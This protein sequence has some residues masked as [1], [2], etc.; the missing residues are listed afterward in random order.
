M[1]IRSKFIL[2]IVI[3]VIIS[4]AVISIAVSVKLGGT[5]TE[6][7]EMSSQEE[8]VLVD[9]TVNQI[10]KSPAEV[11]K[12][13][14]SLPSLVNGLGN[15]TKYFELPPG[16]HPIERD[17]MSPAERS[18]FKTFERL[19]QSHPE[20][21]YVYA[22]LEDGGYTQSPDEAMGAGYDPRKRPWYTQGM[23]SSED[24]TLLSAYITTEGVPNIGMVSKVRDA[25]GKV[26]GISAADISL[27]KLTEIASSIH[28]G[29]TGYIM[30]VQGDGTIL[31]DPRHK[32]Y[33][34]K[35]MTELS[36]AFT[37]LSDTAK[38][39]VEDLS[40]DDKDMFGCVHVSPET[41]WKYIALI[42]RSEI[43]A[44]SNTAIIQ[45]VGI[46]LV[47]ALIF[48][49]LG[50][51]VANSLTKP[52]LMSGDFTK[53]IA[54]G[55]L[56]ASINISGKDEIATLAKDLGNMGSKLRQIVG[57]VRITVDGVATGS[58]ELSATAETLAQGATEQASN[59]EEVASSMEQMVANISQNAENAKETEQIASRSAA[60]AEK[61]GAAVAQTV[62]AMREI[63]DKISV[64][65]EI[66]RQTN[67][68]A[69]N[70]AIEAARA[71]EHGKGFA[72]VAA[73]VRKLAERSGSAAG[74]ISELSASSVQVA[75]EAGEMLAKMVPDI[76]H[77]A[78]L[79]QE[80]TAASNEQ[81]TGSEGV[82]SAIHQ[83]DQ[84]IQQIAA[85]S[86]EMSGTSA[87]LSSQATHLKDTVAF[88]NI[89]NLGG[90]SVT[91]TAHSRK[92]ALEVGTQPQVQPEGSGVALE[93]D[94]SDEFERF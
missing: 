8:L 44:S 21:A 41:G 17:T 65:E 86:E 4:V 58:Q 80:I 18:A 38:G 28:I 57:E 54:S 87:E 37:T 27:Q 22:G 88:F 71:G 62:S 84:V 48:A 15:W 26:I 82:N 72:V 30:I 40:I 43:M 29:K 12:F 1:N 83:L 75:E 90:A 76:K 56:M 67:L 60:A 70:A 92:P 42:E 9:G 63:A 25:S 53:Q 7:F 6:Q 49:L 81:Q 94:D 33:V 74:E 85:A 35:K 14:A 34:F 46:G 20:F 31:A 11:T 47:V 78:E 77:T 93:M 73:E 23:Q 3:P 2:S 39:L 24:T 66:A 5:V 61:G 69:L 68:L 55:D 36:E 64:V 79:I 52:I 50:W 59:V 16:K 51:K 32:D 89:G 10:L 45:T 19:M 91:R 13:V